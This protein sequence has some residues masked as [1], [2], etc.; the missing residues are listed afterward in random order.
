M[1]LFNSNTWQISSIRE[2]KLGSTG[3]PEEQEH[4]FPPVG[5]NF[6][7]VCTSSDWKHTKADFDKARVGLWI[8]LE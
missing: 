1:K 8:E 7:Q 6:S 5:Q 2:M 3:L 4:E